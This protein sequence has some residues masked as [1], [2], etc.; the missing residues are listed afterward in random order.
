MAVNSIP[1]CWD[2]SASASTTLNSNPERIWGVYEYGANKMLRM[3]N[4]FV[5]SGTALIN[6][7]TI[8]LPETPAYELSFD[9]A[10]TATC[11]L[12]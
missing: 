2:N 8:V 4:Y 5:S 7:P 6:M 11:D 12:W 1:T 3:Y 9:Y 10:H